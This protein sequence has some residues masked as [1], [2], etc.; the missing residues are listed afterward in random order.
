MTQATQIHF[1]HRLRKFYVKNPD[2]M[3]TFGPPTVGPRLWLQMH[4]IGLSVVGEHGHHEKMM[5]E[6]IQSMEALLAEFPRIVWQF[7]PP[8]QQAPGKKHW[9]H[10]I[11]CRAWMMQSVVMW[12]MIIVKKRCQNR[13]NK[14]KLHLQIFPGLSGNFAP[15][16]KV[17]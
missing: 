17:I 10:L 5:W 3:S 14:W 1:F 6:Q 15:I 9:Q 12:S 11:D 16:V 7:V 13:P 4:A 2:A 8:I